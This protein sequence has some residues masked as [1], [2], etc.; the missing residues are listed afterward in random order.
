LLDREKLS[1]IENA[2]VAIGLKEE[3]AAEPYERNGRTMIGGTGFF[4]SDKCVMTAH[5]VLFSLFEASK[6][7]LQE[8]NINTN[9]AAFQLVIDVGASQAFLNPFEV[10]KAARIVP[11]IKLQEY[12]AP[13]NLDVGV[14]ECNSS[15]E[16]VLKIKKPHR[17]AIN[18]DVSMCSFTGNWQSMLLRNQEYLGMR[19]GPV[20]QSGQVAGLM[21]INR[22]PKPYAIQTNIIATAGCSGSPILDSING[23]VV[24]I[25]QK[26]IFGNSPVVHYDNILDYINM[27]PRNFQY[28][29]YI[30]TLVEVGIIFGISNQIPYRIPGALNYLGKDRPSKLEF[31][32][33][34]M[35][36]DYNNKWL[37]SELHVQA[38]LETMN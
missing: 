2:T 14:I 16:H 6:M 28:P 26:S 20:W 30:H 38:V 10:K 1:S 13:A 25:A 36:K 9:L 21:P 12:T 32:I 27:E 23:E 7:I 11:N 18:D 4:V 35:R 15:S 3:G 37:L 19:L 29:K 24:A 33:T 22:S 8:D 31:D 5:H 34:G 17:P